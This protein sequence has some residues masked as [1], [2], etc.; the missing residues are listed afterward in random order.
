MQMWDALVPVQGVLM[1]RLQTLVARLLLQ[2]LSPRLCP[3]MF[4][5]GIVSL[6]LLLQGARFIYGCHAYPA[7]VMSMSLVRTQ[8]SCT[9]SHY[10]DRSRSR[11]W[12]RDNSTEL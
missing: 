4:V 11:S 3:G 10:N 5:T 8:R 2:D 12:S 1:V 7:L 9:C 6:H